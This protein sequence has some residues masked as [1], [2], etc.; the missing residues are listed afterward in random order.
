M[1]QDS[2]FQRLLPT[3]PQ[4]PAEPGSP[5][6]VELRPVLARR[7]SL[8]PL[9]ATMPLEAEEPDTRTAAAER[10]PAEPRGS[11][12]APISPPAVERVLERVRL[13]G[14][15]P[16][17][18][19]PPARPGVPPEPRPEPRPRQRE[20]EPLGPA[21]T[22]GK[23]VPA[24]PAAHPPAPVSGREQIPAAPLPSG[25]AARPAALTPAPPAPPNSSRQERDG[26]AGPSLPSRVPAPRASDERP[27]NPAR[28]EPPATIPAPVTPPPQPRTVVRERVPA[29]VPAPRALEPLVPVPTPGQKE[30]PAAQAPEPGTAALAPRSE[31]DAGRKAPE[32][33]EL[34]QPQPQA[35]EHSPVIRP[36][37]PGAPP[38]KPAAPAGVTV[39]IGRIEIIARSRPSGAARRVSQPA[40][41]HQIET[42]S[43]FGT[44]R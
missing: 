32:R 30:E 13:E 19:P 1:R 25:A 36:A 23:Q 8:A 35:R 33:I 14:V 16:Q 42:R 27:E 10:E 7:R 18:A 38:A 26:T 2:I 31:G 37:A 9:P 44:G 3:G 15:P 4:A 34:P 11:S 17:P 6:T 24:G 41:R 21:P 20:T 28:P 29:P 12:G 40:R 43:P 22:G 39:R 5:V